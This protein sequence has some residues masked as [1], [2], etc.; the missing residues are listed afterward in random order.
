MNNE[1][2]KN[3][4]TLELRAPYPSWDA[5]W[6]AYD[7]VRNRGATTIDVGVL[8]KWGLSKANAR[9]VLPAL[10]FLG[11]VDKDGN[12][13]PLWSELAV[14]DEERYKRAVEGMLRSAYSKLLEAYSDAFSETDARLS[15]AIGDVYETSASTRPAVVNFL[16]R[17]LAEAGL[18]TAP[19]ATRGESAES[20]G[21]RTTQRVARGTRAN[22]PVR[23]APAIRE[24]NGG[25]N[26]QVH[27]NVAPDISEDELVAFFRRLD[28]ARK[29]ATEGD[30]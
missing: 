22:A 18:V 3:S 17:M 25:L 20:T 21:A 2:S 13:L 16:R 26:V 28:R 30:G 7:K 8:E 5:F 24:S 15:D 11:I 4:E 9:K 19:A 14:K 6:V 12:P 29:R 23:V 27:V 10:K 1:E